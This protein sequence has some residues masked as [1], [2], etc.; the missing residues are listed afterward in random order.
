MDPR[1]AFLKDC[2]LIQWVVS[3]IF[4]VC[5]LSVKCLNAYKQASMP[6]S[7]Q[8]HILKY[9]HIKTLSKIE[10]KKN[11]TVNDEG[12]NVFS[13]LPKGSSCTSPGLP[14]LYPG[15]TALIQKAAW[16]M[17]SEIQEAEAL[18]MKP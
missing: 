14:H 18:I 8:T 10:V 5:I 12:A 6:I 15:T 2:S 16:P 1:S 7:T 3:N 17:L 4:E 9:D 11:N 13:L